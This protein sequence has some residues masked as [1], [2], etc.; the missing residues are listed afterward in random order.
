MSKIIFVG[1][2]KRFTGYSGSGNLD[3]SV[4]FLRIHQ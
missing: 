1:R 4:Y 3:L 2:Q